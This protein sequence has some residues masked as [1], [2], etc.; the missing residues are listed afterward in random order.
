MKKIFILF[1]LSTV[2]FS[3]SKKEIE[4]NCQQAQVMFSNDINERTFQYQNRV[5]Y[6]INSNLD[7]D[8]VASEI[9]RISNEFDNDIMITKNR[10]KKKYPKCNF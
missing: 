7:S 10:Y 9:N 6:L 3:C 2:L 1:L 8:Y 5:N 4:Y